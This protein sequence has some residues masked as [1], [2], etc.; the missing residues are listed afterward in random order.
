MHLKSFSQLGLKIKRTHRVMKRLRSIVHVRKVYRR[1]P[2]HTQIFVH[3]VGMSMIP[4]SF[5]T[6]G[7]Q[8]HTLSL[9]AVQSVT[10]D[11]V[12]MEV[13]HLVCKILIHSIK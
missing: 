4:A 8:H 6:F 1:I 2:A 9:D 7:V 3:K 5:Y 12:N 10:V 13:L 11:T